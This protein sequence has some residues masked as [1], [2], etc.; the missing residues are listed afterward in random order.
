MSQGVSSLSGC[1]NSVSEHVTGVSI[2]GNFERDV[3]GDVEGGLDQQ[4][5][6]RGR[7]ANDLDKMDARGR[8]GCGLL[9]GGDDELMG[10]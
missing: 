8:A 4:D 6:P 2:T 1:W 9:I 3:Y 7:A 5:D 10:A